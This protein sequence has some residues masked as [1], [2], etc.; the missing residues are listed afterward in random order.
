M[1]LL[2]GLC[3]WSLKYQTSGVDFIAENFL[4]IMSILYGINMYF[5][6]FGAVS[7]VKVNAHWFHV[8]ERGTFG[9]IFGILIS[10]GLYF[11]YDWGGPIAESHGA[12]WAFYAPTA[13]LLVFA[14]LDYFLVF[15]KPSDTGHEDF[16]PGDAKLS[17]EG[18]RVGVATMAGRMIRNPVILTIIL[19][20][21]SIPIRVPVPDIKL[22]D[23]I[24]PV[25]IKNTVNNIEYS[26]VPEW[27]TKWEWCR[28]YVW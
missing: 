16:D 13:I 22:T 26:A 4:M 1:N 7:I 10:L 27:C 8:K 25:T 14:L 24:N 17:E 18:E 5:Q 2:M 19:I 3:A 11:A 9:G 12:Q 23:P 6:S 15:D 28:R 20:E 21:N